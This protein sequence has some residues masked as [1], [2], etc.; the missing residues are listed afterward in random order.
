M[1]TRLANDRTSSPRLAHGTVSADTRN[2]PVTAAPLGR[3]GMW[4]APTVWLCGG[5]LAVAGLA[6]VYTV[7]PSEVGFYP[8]CILYRL[9]GW[10]CPGCGAT[11]ALHALLHGDVPQALAFNPVFVF[12]MPIMGVAL[13]WRGLEKWRGRPPCTR[14]RLPGS[15]ILVLAALLVAFGLLRNLPGWPF[16]LLAPHRIA[17]GQRAGNASP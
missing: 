16:E 12:L 3:S 14:P 11:R 10:H 7:D 17:A 1:T 4:R 2:L 6:L 13:A 9:T 5:V 8:P 15:V